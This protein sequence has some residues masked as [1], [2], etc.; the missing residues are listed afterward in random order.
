MGDKIKLK[1]ENNTTVIGRMSSQ[2]FR[3]G[4]IRCGHLHQQSRT[5]TCFIPG[6]SAL[7]VIDNYD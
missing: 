6:H 3:A 4:R 1:M 7:R 5:Y 2:W